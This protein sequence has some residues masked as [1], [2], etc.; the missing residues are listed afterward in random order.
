MVGESVVPSS[1]IPLPTSPYVHV[2]GVF[3][4]IA[5]DTRRGRHPDWII[6]EAAATDIGGVRR[7]GGSV[8]R[9]SSLSDLRCN[10]DG[11]SWLGILTPRGRNRTS[12]PVY[13]YDS[14]KMCVCYGITGTGKH[15]VCEMLITRNSIPCRPHKESSLFPVFAS[16]FLHSSAA[17]GWQ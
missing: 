9:S 7:G 8:G 10:A 4:F 5:G 15:C 12:M 14:P 6:S 11:Y 13:W 1:C 17:V 2:C 3:F 16:F